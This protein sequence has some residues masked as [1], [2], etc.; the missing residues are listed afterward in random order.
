MNNCRYQ[1]NKFLL[2]QKFKSTRHVIIIVVSIKASKLKKF[3]FRL[4]LVPLSIADRFNAEATI[5]R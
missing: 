3:H 4:L 1:S 2:K 5:D